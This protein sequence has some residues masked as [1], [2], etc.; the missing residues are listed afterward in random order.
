M[1]M[2]Q[3]CSELHKELDKGGLASTEVDVNK[4]Q[5]LLESYS[6]NSTDVRICSWLIF[7]ILVAEICI[8]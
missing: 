3:L 5:K 7:I 1:N 2:E 6:A 8:F 4:V